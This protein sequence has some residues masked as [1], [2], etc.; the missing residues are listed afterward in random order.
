MA[1]AKRTSTS[2]VLNAGTAKKALSDLKKGSFSSFDEYDSI[3]LDAAEMMAQ[4][5]DELYLEGIKSLSVEAAKAL[6][7]HVGGQSL[8]LGGLEQVDKA[9]AH[10]LARHQG[11]LALNG[12][13][14]LPDDVALALAS[15]EYDLSLDGLEVLSENSGLFAHKAGLSL[16][17]LNAM[18]DAVADKLSTKEGSLTLAFDF[19][20]SITEL[21]PS[22]AKL[23]VRMQAGNEIALENLTTLTVEAAKELAKHDDVVR[24]GLSDLSDEVKGILGTVQLELNDGGSGLDF[25]SGRTTSDGDEMGAV[26]FDDEAYP[27]GIS[28]VIDDL[29]LD[30]WDRGY[31][32]GTEN[33]TWYEVYVNA[34][35]KA[36]YP[37]I[38]DDFDNEDSVAFSFRGFKG[39]QLGNYVDNDQITFFVPDGEDE[40]TL[41]E[42]TDIFS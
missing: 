42:M 15:C 36:S 8:Y 25:S 33:G 3:D 27:D 7:G 26:V 31:S 16:R 41:D 38:P 29:N 14:A 32:C 4:Y 1:S 11:P 37:S 24:L 17:G 39:L 2:N 19:C 10:E 5:A 30:V 9:V 12:L 35:T 22:M 28:D 18:S 13:H 23:L 20:D 40:W 34:E 6:A 21:S